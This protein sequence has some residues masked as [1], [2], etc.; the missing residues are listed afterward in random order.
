[1]HHNSDAKRPHDCAT[2]NV[3][4]ARGSTI[5]PD[6]ARHPWHWCVLIQLGHIY[7]ISRSFDTLTE[8]AEDF[9][10]NGPA[11]VADIEAELARNY[12]APRCKPYDI[13]G[14]NPA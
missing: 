1:M 2:V 12:S 13:D 6:K 3:Q 8:A 5:K 10:L 14:I 7:H 9:R 4:F 11:L